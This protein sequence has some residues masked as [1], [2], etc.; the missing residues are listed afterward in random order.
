MANQSQEERD[1]QEAYQ[2][3]NKEHVAQVMQFYDVEEDKRQHE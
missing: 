3:L 2:K 1:V